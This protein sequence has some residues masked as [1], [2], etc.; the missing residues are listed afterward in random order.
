MAG[1]GAEEVEAQL[2]EVLASGDL[3]EWTEAL[4]VGSTSTVHGQTVWIRYRLTDPKVRGALKL[5]SRQAR[6]GVSFSAQQ[7]QQDRK[8]GGEV[9][10]EE[11]LDVVATVGSAA[12]SS[13]S[14]LAP[15]LA[16]KTTRERSWGVHSRVVGG[17]KLRV[18]NYQPFDMQL[19]VEIYVDGQDLLGGA[20]LLTAE[21][22]LLTVGFQV[23][24]VGKDE[25]KPNFE[26]LSPVDLTQLRH[27]DLVLNAA[28][29]SQAIPPMIMALRD[30]GLS[31]NS[32]TAVAR[33]VIRQLVNEQSVLNRSHGIPGRIVSNPFSVPHR[34]GT[35]SGTATLVLQP[36]ALT[37]WRAFEGQTALRYDIGWEGQLARGRAGMSGLSVRS[38]AELIKLRV[39]GLATAGYLGISGS[40]SHSPGASS[41]TGLDHGSKTTLQWGGKLDL[42]AGRA[43]AMITFQANVTVA[44]VTVRELPIQ[45]AVH[46]H[47]SPSFRNLVLGAHPSPKLRPTPPPPLAFEPPMV[48]DLRGPGFGVLRKLPA[49]GDVVGVIRLLLIGQGLD[50]TGMD[51]ALEYWY[52]QEALEALDVGG[53]AHGVVHRLKGKGIKIAMAVQMLP[54][55]SASG[56]ESTSTLVDNLTINLRSLSGSSTSDTRSAETEL[57]WSGGRACVELIDRVELD[58]VTAEYSG[59]VAWSDSQTLADSVS[60]YVRIETEGD[61]Q[62]FTKPVYYVISVRVTRRGTSRLERRYL[63]DVGLG[64]VRE[65]P[66]FRPAALATT[67]GGRP[68]WRSLASPR[69]ATG[70]GTTGRAGD[71]GH[72]FPPGPARARPR[73][74]AAP[75][76]EGQGRRRPEGARLPRVPWPGGG[77]LPGHR[78]PARA[79]AGGRD[80]AG[81]R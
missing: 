11:A 7:V 78:G 24:L 23:G 31:A 8:T 15:S 20:Q 74:R 76:R 50:T 35:F 66:P 77:H 1:P 28:G 32:T 75:A 38:G 10:I 29:I 3:E 54:Q 4:Q 70:R 33:Q 51:H 5:P 79:C 34:L 73:V 30:A 81:P 56:L 68:T 14:G 18:Q 58:A 62:D 26:A 60:S 46:Q 67:A 69:G 13:L 64:P 72:D 41:T 25:D 55:P 39:P 80:D 63:T 65:R 43:T 42:F 45:F 36:T 44:P 16:T 21:R 37:Y 53:L 49:A 61:A 27:F 57:G 47:E 48:R 17:R 9:G 71:Q 12:L 40:L 19:A 59:S 6:F 22:H 2:A 52:G